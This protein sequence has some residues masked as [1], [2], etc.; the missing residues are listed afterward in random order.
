VIV[1]DVSA[2]VRVRRAKMAQAV[3]GDVAGWNRTV[4]VGAAAVSAPRNFGASDGRQLAPRRQSEVANSAVIELQRS[5]SETQYVVRLFRRTT[6]LY[7]R[8]VYLFIVIIVCR[9]G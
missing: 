2:A 4:S 6:S 7:T 5:G 8:T 1:F 9:H 3:R